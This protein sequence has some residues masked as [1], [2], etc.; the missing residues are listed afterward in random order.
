[1]PQIKTKTQTHTHRSAIFTSG[2]PVFGGALRAKRLSWRLASLAIASMALFLVGSEPTSAAPFVFTKSNH[3]VVGGSFVPLTSA[4]ITDASVPISGSHRVTVQLVSN[5][6]VDGA[7]VMGEEDITVTAN[8]AIDQLQIKGDST[9]TLIA[10]DPAVELFANYDFTANNGVLD[11]EIEVATDDFGFAQ[12]IFTVET[13]TDT[14]GTALIDTRLQGE[15]NFELG[16]RYG[17]DNIG[18][19]LDFVP[20]TG[21]VTVSKDRVTGMMWSEFYGWIDLQ[22]VG[23][24]L[25]VDI[26]TADRAD[27]DGYAWNSKT[28]YI[29]FGAIEGDSGGVYIDGDGYIHGT[30]FSQEFGYFSFG[31]FMPLNDEN[32]SQQVT[33][34]QTS[35]ERRDHNWAKTTWEFIDNNAPIITLIAPD[36][37]STSGNRTPT[38]SFHIEEEDGEDVGFL[39]VLEREVSPGVWSVYRSYQLPVDPDGDGEDNLWPPNGVGENH[40]YQFGTDIS[41]GDYRWRMRAFDQYLAWS[42]YTDYRTFTIDNAPPVTTLIFPEDCDTGPTYTDCTV[43]HF[44]FFPGIPSP[45]RPIFKFEIVEPDDNIRYIVEISNNDPTFQPI[46]ILDQSSPL[47]PYA[48]AKGAGNSYTY[49]PSFNLPAGELYWRVVATDIYGATE[50]PHPYNKFRIFNQEPTI[51][52]VALQ[53]NNNNNIGTE[54]YDTAPTLV[55]TSAD[56]DTGASGI[57][58]AHIKVY[59]RNDIFTTLQDVTVDHI[60]GDYQYTLG[61]LD[62]PGEYRVEIYITDEDGEASGT[63]GIDFDIVSRDQFGN[64]GT[65]VIQNMKNADNKGRMIGADADSTNNKYAWNPTNG[66]LDLNP[67]GGG[68]IV[69]NTRVLGYAWNDTLGWIRMNCI[70][71]DADTGIVNTENAQIDDECTGVDGDWGVKNEIDDDTNDFSK[72]TGKA[73]IEATGD[74]LYFDEQAYLDDFGG[75]KGDF[76][77]IDVQISCDNTEVTPDGGDGHVTLGHFSG[78]AWS[79]AMGW[80]A[81]GHADLAALG[82]PVADA[83]DFFSITEWSCGENKEPQLIEENKYIVFDA[84]E[85]GY[86]YAIA[87]RSNSPFSEELICDDNSGGDN[88]EI[89]V[90][91]INDPN[92]P[93]DISKITTLSDLNDFEIGCENPGGVIDGKLWLTI[94]DATPNYISRKPGI[95]R[96][97][98]TVADRQGYKTEFPKNEDT[99]HDFSEEFIFQIVAAEPDLTRDET[100]DVDIPDTLVAD[101]DESS[102]ARFT[103]TLVDKFGNAVQREYQYQDANGD[104]NGVGAPVILKEVDLRAVFW[105]DV[106][107]DQVDNTGTIREATIFSPDNINDSAL[108]YDEKNPSHPTVQYYMDDEDY[109]EEE[110]DLVIDVSSYAPTDDLYD[111]RLHRLETTVQQVYDVTNRRLEVGQTIDEPQQTKVQEVNFSITFLPIIEA[112]VE[113]FDYFGLIDSEQDYQPIQLINN[114]P[115]VD[116][117]SYVWLTLLKTVLDGGEL[118]GGTYYEDVAVFDNESLV[119]D[120]QITPYKE[121]WVETSSPFG[122]LKFDEGEVSQFVNTIKD[123]MELPNAKRLWIDYRGLQPILKDDSRTYYLTGTPRRAEDFLNDNEYPRLVQA[124]AVALGGKIVKFPLESPTSS[125]TMNFVLMAIAGALHGEDYSEGKIVGKTSDVEEYSIVGKVYER[126]EIRR[127]MYENYTDLTGGKTPTPNSVIS[128]TTI[129][130]RPFDTWNDLDIGRGKSSNVTTWLQDGKVRWIEKA[131]E[132]SSLSVTIGDAD[133][134]DAWD[135]TPSDQTFVIPQDKEQITLLVRGGNV[136]IRD[137]IVVED[138]STLG[139]IVLRSPGNAQNGEQGNVFIDPSVTRIEAAIYA[140]GS[141]MSAL[142]DGTPE[143][144]PNAITEKEIFDSYSSDSEKELY[145]NQLVIKGSIVSQNIAG[146]G[147]IPSDDVWF[148]EEC[149][150]QGENFECSEIK[151]YDFGFIRRYILTSDTNDTDEDRIDDDIDCHIWDE[152]NSIDLAT[153]SIG[154]LEITGSSPPESFNPQC[155]D[156]PDGSL[157]PYAELKDNGCMPKYKRRIAAM[158]GKCAINTSW[159]EDPDSPYII[160]CSDTPTPDGT[161]CNTEGGDLENKRIGAAVIIE[162]DPK[163]KNLTPIGM[164]LPAIVDFDRH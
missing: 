117:E 141:I 153:Y 121:S 142:D 73:L 2:R 17:E 126:P 54:T 114:S 159:C 152:D 134:D 27:I 18:G 45:R 10:G 50:N 68:V 15:E 113:N 160:D 62:S 116:V 47:S 108:E 25:T 55:W 104:N 91:Q 11:T 81:F 162:Y 49:T 154:C 157:R 149:L 105:D 87:E 5:G 99:P 132:S 1:M 31:E 56:A 95:Y 38:F 44:E 70:A 103:I 109:F 78:N 42:D 129:E 123:E 144:I 61:I 120:N 145:N 66:W 128:G 7:F 156:A 65:V 41:P 107:L 133:D 33:R 46:N 164:N 137:N 76:P 72:L 39:I 111:V 63:V 58:T 88:T 112:V 74:Y 53:D 89:I 158:D 6:E 3:Q 130:H 69:E 86:S 131:Q 75:D 59:D 4:T 21:G 48:P 60:K 155:Q 119:S 115:N 13:G 28:G 138:G 146:T 8:G 35:L 36:D 71:P 22:P 100:I 77:D 93:D 26:K 30:A 52:A 124:M 161:G 110:R 106:M 64:V 150:N 127:I 96:V 98:G 51:E 101:G 102:R 122:F 19:L 40:T 139:I 94:K 20:S 83:E 23:G 80:V 57:L 84:R 92:D 34:V 32:E 140:D 97:S 90:E 148:P 147:D 82:M 16:M 118:P 12:L 24:G 136:Y 29:Y 37:A 43:D 143:K 14:T 79:P 163:I 9:I 67:V 151:R 125:N 85:G 135:A